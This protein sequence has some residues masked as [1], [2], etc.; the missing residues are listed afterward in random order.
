MIL[1]I[2]GLYFPNQHSPISLVNGSTLCSLQ[3][4]ILLVVHNVHLFWCRQT[5]T[6]HDLATFQGAHKCAICMCLSKPRTCMISAQNYARS[7]QK[8]YK[9]II[10]NN[11]ARL[12]MAKPNIENVKGWNLLA[13]KR[14]EVQIVKLSLQV[15]QRA[16]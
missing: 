12:Y 16:W 6:R 11:F 15:K 2:R 9:V 10:I 1:T 13:V 14:T 8:S 4:T 7:E 5:K 3:G